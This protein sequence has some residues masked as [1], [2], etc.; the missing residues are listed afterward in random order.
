M[1]AVEVRPQPGDRAAYLIEWLVR[2][3][4]GQEPPRSRKAILRE[5]TDL[6][7]QVLPRLWERLSATVYLAQ[8]PAAGDVT[9]YSFADFLAAKAQEVGPAGDAVRVKARAW[10]DAED[11]R[12]RGW[13]SR[14][15]QYARYDGD[16]QE[17]LR[18][19]GRETGAEARQ[20]HLWRLSFRLQKD[21]AA[22]GKDEALASAVEAAL[23]EAVGAKNEYVSAAAITAMYYLPPERSRKL[24]FEAMKARRPGLLHVGSSALERLAGGLTVEEWRTLVPSLVWLLKGG[25]YGYSGQIPA[26]LGQVRGPQALGGLFEALKDKSCDEQ[27]LKEIV[28]AIQAVLG[29]DFKPALPAKLYDPSPRGTPAGQAADWRNWYADNC[30]RVSWD[31]S[32]GV[33][34]LKP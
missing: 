27:A 15:L 18:D 6:A 10:L 34:R 5:L 32:G 22:I 31:E 3:F 23:A 16:L 26:L 1:A 8:P 2:P 21:A 28:L 30:D 9:A 17:M 14:V 29:P 20:S 4:S 7:A 19:I 33:Y 11:A 13:A 24:F 12:R 25:G